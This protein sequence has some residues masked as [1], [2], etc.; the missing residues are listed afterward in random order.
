MVVCRVRDNWDNVGVKVKLP[1]YFSVNWRQNYSELIV[2]F[3]P[4]FTVQHRLRHRQ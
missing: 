1:R 2:V 3:A 4:S